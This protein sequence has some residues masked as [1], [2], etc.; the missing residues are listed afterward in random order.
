M[1][2]GLSGDWSMNSRRALVPI[3]AAAAAFALAVLLPFAGCGLPVTGLPGGVDGGKSCDNAA[4]C[5]DGEACTDDVCENG[6]CHSTAAPD[7]LGPNQT[8]G[9]CATSRCV[10]GVLTV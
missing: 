8:A 3:V 1:D 9:D 4:Q 7:G 10:G 5:D 6:L 2:M